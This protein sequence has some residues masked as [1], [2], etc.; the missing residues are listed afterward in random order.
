MKTARRSTSPRRALF[1]FALF[2]AMPLFVLGCPKKEAP[3]QDAGPAP[4][5]T[6]SA[7]VTQ[8]APLEEDAGPDSDAGDADADAKKWA[9]QAIDPNVAKIR[10]CCAAIQ[11]QARQ[12]GTTS[13]E[14]M[15]L[16]TV[17][18]QCYAMANNANAK[19]PEFA[20]IR[21]LLQGRSIPGC[22]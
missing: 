2:S 10:A 22:Q 15:Y 11:G 9:G 5:P 3:V 19:A 7:S 8:L 13:P 1:A 6:P 18:G 12:L 4:E 17:A 20:T 16:N 14:G 21:G